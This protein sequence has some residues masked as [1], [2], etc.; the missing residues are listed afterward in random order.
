MR[1]CPVLWAT[2]RRPEP[3]G[4]QAI[5]VT[6]DG[7]LN[8]TASVQFGSRTAAQVGVASA[9]PERS[10]RRTARERDFVL[11]RHLFLNATLQNTTPLHAPRWALLAWFRLGGRPPGLRAPLARI[12]G[13]RKFFS[14]PA[15][16]NVGRWDS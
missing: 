13:R 2:N 14:S 12:A 15:A 9:R 6:W 8:Q 4:A 3:S 16:R 1:T 10:S 5:P 11:M 7:S